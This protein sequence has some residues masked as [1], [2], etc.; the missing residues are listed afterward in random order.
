MR[1]LGGQYIYVKWSE[2]E[3][4]FEVTGTYQGTRTDNYGKECPVLV[5]EGGQRY[6]LNHSGSLEYKI[7]FAEKGDRL[8][9]K[10]KGTEAIK[11]K[12]GVKDVHQFAVFN[13]DDSDVSPDDFDEEPKA[14]G[15]PAE[16][17]LGLD[18]LDGFDDVQDLL[19]A[20]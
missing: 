12:Y 6:S 13:L 9:V 11:T 15:K 3:V 8:L 4:G 7:G 1:E 10:Y 5:G 20:K 17:S 18:S 16:E 14:A 2:K 19:G